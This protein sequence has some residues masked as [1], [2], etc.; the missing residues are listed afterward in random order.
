V[1]Y[2]FMVEHGSQFR[3]QRMCRVLKVSRSGYYRWC[4]SSEGLRAREDRKLLVQI[5]VAYEKSRGRYGSPR[6]YRELHEQGVRCGKHRVE[7]LMR[8]DGLR[9]RRRRSFKVTT[10]SAAGHPVAPNQLNRQ[11]CVARLDTVWAG[12]ITYVETLEGWLY[13]AVLLDLCSRRV[14]GWACSDRITHDLVLW[15]LERAFEQRRPQRGLLHHS[16]RGSQYT[17][18]EYRTALNRQ[19]LE[20]SMS[21]RGDCYDNAVVESFFSTLKAELEG[22]GGYETRRQAQAELFEYIEIFY[23]RQRRHSS[24][25][26]LSPAAY[27]R[28][29]QERNSESKM[30]GSKPAPTGDA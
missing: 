2:A 23:N 4:R 24:L 9:A 15:A 26:Y 17:C 25:G 8:Q 28:A 30:L 22:Y 1:K 12:D 29:Q 6:I 18:E 19:G 14:V 5:R 3:V 20:V 13:L 11:F 27:E 21:R 16:D 10:R 7:R